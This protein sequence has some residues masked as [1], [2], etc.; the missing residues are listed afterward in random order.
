MPYSNGWVCHPTY[1]LAQ[2]KQGWQICC[3]FEF[4]ELGLGFFLCKSEWDFILFSL[5]Y[6]LICSRRKEWV[7]SLQSQHYKLTSHSASQ[8]LLEN[9]LQPKQSDFV[10]ELCW[11]AVKDIRSEMKKGCLSLVDKKKQQPKN[12]TKTPQNFLYPT[13]WCVRLQDQSSLSHTW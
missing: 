5:N 9:L 7:I 10:I 4:G 6:I 11:C 3:G 2:S 8:Q 13:S 12:Q 1:L